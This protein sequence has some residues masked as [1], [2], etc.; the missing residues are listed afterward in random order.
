MEN[1]VI[2]KEYVEKNYI[3]IAK[4]K[5]IINN[6]AIVQGDRYEMDYQDVQNAIAE[7]IEMIRKDLFGG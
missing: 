2:A 6:I 4:A 7:T 5:E 3:E 1:K